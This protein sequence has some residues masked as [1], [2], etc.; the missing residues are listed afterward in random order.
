MQFLEVV[1]F[2]KV[3]LLSISITIC[4]NLGL[5]LSTNFI[6]SCCAILHA[7]P[8]KSVAS[9]EELN[10]TTI[11]SCFCS[12]STCEP[13]CNET[14]ILIRNFSFPACMNHVT[15]YYSITSRSLHSLVQYRNLLYFEQIVKVLLKCI[16]SFDTIDLILFTLCNN[17]ASHGSIVQIQ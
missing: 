10:I 4:Q 15:S 3:F 6:D 14:K 13:C 16:T 12:S 9:W 8:V 2:Y 17:T 5:P 7:P 11:L 1:Y